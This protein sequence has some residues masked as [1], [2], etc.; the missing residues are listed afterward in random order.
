MRYRRNVRAWDIELVDAEQRMFCIA[1][2]ALP[3][4]LHGGNEQHVG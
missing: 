2:H 3:A 4:L 1:H